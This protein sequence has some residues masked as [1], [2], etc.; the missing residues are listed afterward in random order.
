MNQQFGNNQNNFRPRFHN[1]RGSNRGSRG[2]MV[3]HWQ[4]RSRN[5]SFS[6]D[7]VENSSIYQRFDWDD[8]VMQQPMAT[9]QGSS[10][11]VDQSE[12][13]ITP[14]HMNI[15]PENV[16]LFQGYDSPFSTF[17]KVPVK[18]LSVTYPCVESYYQAC[19]VSQLVGQNAAFELMSATNG[20]KAK[21]HARN[22]IRGHKIS[23]LDVE[24][25][26]RSFGVNAIYYG[27]YYKFLQNRELR[28]K[29]FET[30]DK[31][32]IHDYPKDALYSSGCDEKTLKSWLE[33][34]IGKR[35]EVSHR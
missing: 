2:S 12:F 29:L 10:N 32:I 17:Y 33:D 23:P 6:S 11:R 26:K 30:G 20:A 27:T 25:W 8:W 1:G 21:Q 28:K 16:V 5:D 31:L 9:G 4:Y 13:S 14:I 19:K 18:V 34:H 35:I 7:N 3:N 24:E 15:D 22:I